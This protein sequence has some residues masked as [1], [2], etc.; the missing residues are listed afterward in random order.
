MAARIFH[1]L[2]FLGLAFGTAQAQQ[3]NVK[4]VFIEIDHGALHCP[5]LGLKFKEYFT[6]DTVQNLVI[7]RINST[8]K[9]DAV[10]SRWTQEAFLR[11]AINQK[12]GY[13]AEEIKTIQISN[14]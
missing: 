3:S 10:E 4:N 5:F 2:F 13:P 7:D 1:F 14:P 6:N 9:F 8:A 12:V 11:F